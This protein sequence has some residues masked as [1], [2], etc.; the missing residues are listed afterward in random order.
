MADNNEIQR[1]TIKGHRGLFDA[2]NDAVEYKEGSKYFR[3]KV[4]RQF[5]REYIN[6]NKPP[7][8]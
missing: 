6:E 7:H 3:T 1:M 5:M 2:F 8:K 4:L